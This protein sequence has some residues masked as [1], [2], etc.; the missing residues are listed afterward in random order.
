M[1]TIIYSVHTMTSSNWNIFH[2]TGH[3]C[4]EFT[5]PRWIP[6]TK[7][8]DAELWCLLD[9]RPNKR[10]SKQLWAWWFE[11]QSRPLWRHRNAHETYL[12]III[13]AIPADGSVIR[14]SR[15]WALR[16]F[17]LLLHWHCLFY[18]HV[19]YQQW[20]NKNCELIIPPTAHIIH[21]DRLKQ[22]IDDEHQKI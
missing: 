5:G 3:L 11:T 15:A 2:V 22:S 8:S 7:A 16:R 21:R 6:H 20:R 1:G 4:R 10:L 18:M 17:I 19:L 12:A 14:V 13:C 9:L